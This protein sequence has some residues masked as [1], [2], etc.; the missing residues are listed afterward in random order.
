[1]P[2]GGEMFFALAA[3]VVELE[4]EDVGRSI[5]REKKAFLPP[6]PNNEGD[7]F[8]VGGVGNKAPPVFGASDAGEIVLAASR[9]AFPIL[10]LLLKA[11]DLPWLLLLLLPFCFRCGSRFLKK[12][13]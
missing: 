6:T 2:G 10:L 8:V 5:A 3:A 12:V 9:F 1:M 11:F 4:L 7:A 13:S